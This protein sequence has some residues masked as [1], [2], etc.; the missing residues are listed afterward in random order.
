MHACASACLTD[1][2][3]VLAR[4]FVYR[5]A[6]PDDDGLYTWERVSNAQT[7]GYTAGQ[8]SHMTISD[9]DQVPGSS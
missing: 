1:R 4:L 5:R 7:P 8:L 9:S 6:E 3:C 2:L